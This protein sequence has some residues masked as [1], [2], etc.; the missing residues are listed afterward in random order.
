M[1]F[2]SR[3][4]VFGFNDVK[5]VRPKWGKTSVCAG[6]LPAI[7][8]MKP[9]GILNVVKRHDIG[10]RNFRASLSTTG[11]Q[12]G[13]P[14]A[15]VRSRNH[16]SQ[17]LPPSRRTGVFCVLPSLFTIENNKGVLFEMNNRLANVARTLAID[18]SETASISIK[19]A[20]Y[21]RCV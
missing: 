14:A 17:Q 5:R 18:S 16:R 4:S 10:V 7:F 3:S 20:S 13:V 6:E 11:A 12:F 19:V 1:I 21:S 8:M 2:R 9:F 15:S